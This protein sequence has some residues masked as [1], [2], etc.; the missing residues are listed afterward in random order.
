M[1]SVC[2][3]TKERMKNINK[4]SDTIVQHWDGLDF[5]S[6]LVGEGCF[7][8][9]RKKVSLAITPSFLPDLFF[10]IMMQAREF[11]HIQVL[12]NRGKKSEFGEMALT[13]IRKTQGIR[14]RSCNRCSARKLHV[15]GNFC[16]GL[17]GCKI[18]RAQDEAWQIIWL[19]PIQ[20]QE[21]SLFA[22]STEKSDCRSRHKSSWR[23]D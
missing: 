10:Q 4:K 8:Y 16:E 17:A 14:R 13:G 9:P 2:V 5:A 23:K 15:T 6:W 18:A 12:L 20:G 1:F 7:W 3:K 22:E 11:E 21:L 19:Q